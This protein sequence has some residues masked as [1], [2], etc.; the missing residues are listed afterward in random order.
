V[1]L[2]LKCPQ[3]GGG[4]V[5]TT[6]KT[7]DVAYGVT[8]GGLHDTKSVAVRVPV[9]ECWKCV[10]HFEWTDWVA[11]ELREVAVKEARRNTP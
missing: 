7:E 8:T 9:R 6:W 11:D 4:P 5:T 2:F 1:S 3:C 10:P